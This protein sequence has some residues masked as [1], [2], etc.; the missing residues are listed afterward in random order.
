MIQEHKI[1]LMDY[2]G[3]VLFEYYSY[4]IPTM[5][6]TILIDEGEK[7]FIVN[8]RHF[9]ANHNKVVLLGEIDK[10]VETE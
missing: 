9:S 2:E 8:A 6:D 10:P 4:V 1:I 7:S 5:N 3:E